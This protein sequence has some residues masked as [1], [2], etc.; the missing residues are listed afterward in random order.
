LSY[1]VHRLSSQKEPK[2]ISFRGKCPARSKTVL[3]EKPIKQINHF[4]YVGYTISD[5]GIEIWKRR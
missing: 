2:L 3:Y 4:N 1:K 5:F